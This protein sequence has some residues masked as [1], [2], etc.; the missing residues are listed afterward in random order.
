L[1]VINLSFKAGIPVGENFPIY[2]WIRDVQA[3]VVED[4]LSPPPRMGGTG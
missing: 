1:P 2:V 3:G 4:D